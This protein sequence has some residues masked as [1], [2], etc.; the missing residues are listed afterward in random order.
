MISQTKVNSVFLSIDDISKINSKYWH[1]ITGVKIIKFLN[2]FPKNILNFKQLQYIDISGTDDFY[3]DIDILPPELYSLKNLKY[4]NLA[5]CKLK[6]LP[7]NF[8][9]LSNLEF[10]DLRGNYLDLTTQLHK[11]PLNIKQLGI[12]IF[13]NDSAVFDILAEWK[14]LKSLILD[15]EDID[16][17]SKEIGKL[18]FLTKLDLSNNHLKYLPDEFLNLTNLTTLDLTNDYYLHLDSLKISRLHK[19]TS[20][21]VKGVDINYL[22]FIKQIKNLKLENLSISLFQKQ[23][24]E[25]LLNFLA[26]SK[27]LKSIQI[28]VDQMD[29]VPSKIWKLKKLTELGFSEEILSNIPAD[30]A[31]LT[32]LKVL[33][34]YENNLTSLPPEIGKLTNLEKLD[35]EHNYL[36][37]LPPE[38]G[39][40]KH[41]KY[42]NLSW[43][44]LSS[45]PPEIGKLTNLRALN[46]ETDKYCNHISVLPKEIGNLTNLNYLNL[47]GN[48]LKTLPP[49][50]GRLISLRE[51]YLSSNDLIS[52]PP[53]IG[54]LTNLQ[55]LDLSRNKLTSL[56]TDIAN[57]KNLKYLVLYYNSFSD[58]EIEKIKQLLPNCQVK[59]SMD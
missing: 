40:L 55:S 32:N 16:T 20:L 22:L 33:D 53:E 46:L 14:N 41:L 8:S 31:N 58:A 57:L 9:K 10:L 39:N 30:I 47:I 56:P 43:N 23:G 52:L 2:K 3:N 18:T 37:S 24:Y 1:Y 49:Q 29:R 25:Q 26:S 13:K 11:L 59:D 36:K 27:T 34:V 7:D 38:I 19:L 54:K 6:T 15:V 45:L 51:L 5:Y 50:I 12:S 17:L 21:Y 42:L 28:F 44:K 4:L 35:L 48:R